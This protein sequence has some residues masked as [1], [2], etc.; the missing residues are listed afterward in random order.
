MHWLFVLKLYLTTRIIVL[1]LYRMSKIVKREIFDEIYTHLK[2]KEITIITGARQVGKT[3]ILLSLKEKLL[4]NKIPASSIKF[5]NLDL[6]QDLENISDQTEFIKYLKEELQKEKFLYIFID[7]VQRL[8]NPGLFL[9]G[10]YD[11][12]LPVKFVV[13]GSSSLEIKSKMNETL[14]GR[15]RVFYVW[16]F[17]FKEYIQAKEPVLLDSLKIKHISAINREK[18]MNH[19]YSYVIFGGYPRVVLSGSDREK[20]QILNEIYSSY[21]ERDVVGYLNLK[22]PLKYSKLV[23]LLSD[24]VGSTVNFTQLSNVIGLNIRTLG[25]YIH[26]LE[27]TFVVKLARP[28]FTNKQKEIVKMP[29]I[30]FV[31]TGLRNFALRDFNKFMSRKD[32]GSILENYVFTALMRNENLSVNYYRTKDKNEVDFVVKNLFG[33]II[34]LEVKA[35]EIKHPVFL[36]NLIAFMSRYQVNNG[37]VVNLLTEESALFDDKTLNF[38]LP[39]SVEFLFR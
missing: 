12:H 3:T 21:I 15:K 14:T 23:E 34:P 18:I 35:S 39:Y 11:L 1:K 31:D 19:F 17:S 33:N 24:R 22:E 28:F 20:I 26:A 4:K 27:N 36:K 37:Y 8:E 5:F 13:T 38:I 16:P 25:D 29:K 6:I 32:K 7:E 30:Y 9:K 10:I 2:E